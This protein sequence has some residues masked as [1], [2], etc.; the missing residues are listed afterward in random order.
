MKKLQVFFLIGAAVALLG[1][2]VAMAEIRNEGLKALTFPVSTADGS[3][4]LPDASFGGGTGTG[5]EEAQATCMMTPGGTMPDLLFEL[6]PLPPIN[7][8][9]TVDNYSTPIAAGVL[10]SQRRYDPRRPYNPRTPTIPEYPPPPEILVPEPATLVIV[11]LGITGM[12]VVRRK[13]RR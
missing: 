4:S 1:G 10:P 13:W 11:G 8:E 5:G 7:R 6:P 12:A 3:I 9:R 2:S